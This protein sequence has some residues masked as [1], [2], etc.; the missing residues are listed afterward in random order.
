MKRRTRSTNGE[1]LTT[2]FAGGL[3]ASALWGAAVLFTAAPV[4][5]AGT[6][7]PGKNSVSVSDTVSFSGFAP[8]VVLSGTISKGKKKRVLLVVA[9]LNNVSAAAASNVFFSPR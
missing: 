3:L 1:V 7:S 8:N 2:L 9:S 6:T 5:A 4:N